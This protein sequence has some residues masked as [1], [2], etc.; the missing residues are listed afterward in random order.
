MFSRDIVQSDAF[1]DMPASS[2]ALYFHLGMEADDD[3]FVGNPKK[4]QKMVGVGDDDMK[5]LF[6]KRFI[7]PFPSGV[8]VIKHHRIN[9]NW[10]KINSRRTPYVEELHQ[11][12]IKQNKAYT[13]DSSQGELVESQYRLTPD[14]IQTDSRLKSVVRIEENRVEENR[15]DKRDPPLRKR[16]AAKKEGVFTALGAE[17]IKA[18]I[19]VDPKNKRFYNNPPQRRACDFL[20]EEYGFEAVL[21]RIS[22]LP[23]SN[24]LPYFPSISTPVQLMHK[25]VQLQDAVDRK[26]SE[27]ALKKGKGIII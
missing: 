25:W 9:N 20:V 19:E 17:V 4:M 12:Y 24:K 21:K 8:L 27:S 22:F 5:I 11:L 3:G 2:Q 26:R 18:F 7:L 14:L 23:T 1:L 15:R 10:D 6:T 13:L 16:N